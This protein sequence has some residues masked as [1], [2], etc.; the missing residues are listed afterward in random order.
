[1]SAGVNHVT[2]SSESS[3][4]VILI[5]GDLGLMNVK[6]LQ[7][8]LLQ[9]LDAFDTVHLDAQHLLSADVSIVQLLI[10][11]HKYASQ[12]NKTIEVSGHDN[13]ALQH[14]LTNLGINEES[15]SGA[16]FCFS[17]DTK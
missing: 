6:K 1:M 2:V 9:K 5:Q 16:G 8:D 12:K 15:C 13:T 11:A 7:E 10:S 4:S 17:G 14:L 3:D